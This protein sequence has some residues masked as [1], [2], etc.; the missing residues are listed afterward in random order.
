[1]TWPSW[2]ASS[3][4]S[5]NSRRVRSALRPAAK[6]WN[7]SR[8]TSSSPATVGRGVGAHLGAP[9][10]PD[11]GL[12]ARDDLLR[13][14]RL[15][16]PV[17]GA[18]PQPAHAL[19]D[20]GLPRADD[21]AELREPGAELLEVAPGRRAEHG[22]VDDDGVEPHRDQRV[23]RDGRGEHAVLPAG[24]LQ[25]LG[26]DLHEAGV[27]VEDGDPGRGRR[28]AAWSVIVLISREDTWPRDDGDAR[29]PPPV[30]ALVTS[31]EQDARNVRSTAKR[32]RR[33]RTPGT[34]P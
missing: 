4:I 16:D 14:A 15:G 10:A 11:D 20:G 23:E 30:T 29:D 26:E 22:E 32:A 6:A 13:V 5:S 1:M 18:E 27:G 19:G 34:A 8:R 12:R 9:A 25:P 3:W 17:V 21:D 7:W 31:R 33:P 2:S 24:G 28:S